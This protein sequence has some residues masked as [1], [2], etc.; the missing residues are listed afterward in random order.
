MS[1]ALLEGRLGRRGISAAQV[2]TIGLTVLAAASA[3]LLAMTVAGWAQP[4]MVAALLMAVAL[5]FGMTMPNIMN[6][7]MQP[8]PDIAGAVGAAA[9]SIQLTAG[10]VS[11]G[12]V[13]VLFDGRSALSMA[14][15]MAT[16]SMLALVAYWLLARPAEGR[17]HL[18]AV[19]APAA[20]E[21]GAHSQGCAIPLQKVR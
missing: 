8:L 1:G 18:Q 15:V 9:G 21:G 17:I 10:A 4:A 20:I 2:L 19:E 5:A 16:S 14:G 11:S 3:L 13:A 6:A 12:L 7:T